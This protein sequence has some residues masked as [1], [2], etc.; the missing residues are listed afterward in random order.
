MRTVDEFKKNLA[1]RFSSVSWLEAIDFSKLIIAG[2]CVLNALCQ[3]PFVDTKEQD[4]N[5][6]YYSNNISD[7]ESTVQS[8]VDILNKMISSKSTNV[9][10]MEKVP[11][12]PCYNVVLPCDV[13]LKFTIAFVGN[14]KQPISH[15]LHNF[16]V[17]I[18]Q[19][20]FVGNL[21]FL[22]KTSDFNHYV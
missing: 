12:S 8:T 21:S 10:K 15:I 22:L 16:D 3:S 18:S 5:L 20:A 13:R 14:S 1:T 11:G 4:V 19:V 9:I 17:D 7:F 2:G 6:I